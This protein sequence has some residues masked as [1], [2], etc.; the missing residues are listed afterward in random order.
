MLEKGLD[1]GRTLDG[2][3]VKER[4]DVESFVLA[5]SA[6]CKQRRCFRYA[7]H[8]KHVGYP[9]FHRVDVHCNRRGRALQYWQLINSGSSRGT[10]PT[11]AGPLAYQCQ[12]RLGLAV[13]YESVPQGGYRVYLKHCESAQA[14]GGVVL[15]DVQRDAEVDGTRAECTE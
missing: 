8:S 3:F 13:W 14:P 7:D 4:D 2:W 1:S 10:L 12:G 11:Y 15:K 6:L 5:E 9:R